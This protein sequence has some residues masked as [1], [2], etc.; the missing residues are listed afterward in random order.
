MRDRVGFR[1][2][3]FLL[4]RNK[5]PEFPRPESTRSGRTYFDTFSPN[6]CYCADCTECSNMN[7]RR[8]YIPPCNHTPLMYL[9][10]APP[11]ATIRSA[12]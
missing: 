7:M 8:T 3:F 2:P 9:P 1:E 10:Y 4:S 12:A 6:G 11:K 5:G